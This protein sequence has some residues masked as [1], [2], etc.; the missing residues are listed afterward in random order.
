MISGLTLGGAE[1]Q[2]V[3]LSRELVRRGHAVSIFTLTRDVPRLDELTGR[4]VDVR[5]DQKRQ[6]L[7]FGVLRRLRRH[8]TSWRPDIVHGFLYDGDVYSRL[9]ALGTGLPVLNS[10]RNDNYPLS[11]IQRIGYRVTAA[12]C[13]GVVANTHAGAA[14]ARRLHRMAPEAVHVV[15]NGIDLEEVDARLARSERPARQIFPDGRLKLLCMVAAFR[16][17]KDYHLAL[18]VMRRLVDRD[19][20]WRLICLGDEHSAAMRAYKA[21]VL[22][23]RE[24]L[25][26]EPY[27]LFLGHRRD[28]PELVSSSDLMLLTSL[29]E[30]FPNAVLEAMACGTAV[31]T[32]DYSDVRRIVPTNDQVV[33]SRSEDEIAETVLRCYPRRVEL[34]RRQRA[35]VEQHATMAASAASLLAAYSR[36]AAAPASL[37]PA[38]S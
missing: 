11:L 17:Q 12:L 27:V 26:L 20:S 2:V 13:G 9:A 24:R 4:G 30:G 32:T 8:I 35:W 7:D 33:A 25:A 22:A 14:F 19:D 23:E 36:Y 1:R 34:A 10:E 38:R 6:R 28:V 29:H 21:Q 15:W 37:S 5:V 18:R 3:L 16:P 31:V